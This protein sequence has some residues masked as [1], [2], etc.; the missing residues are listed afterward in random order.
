MRSTPWQ[1]RVIAAGAQAELHRVA[2]APA[3]PPAATASRPSCAAR[4]RARSRA[5]C[6]CASRPAPRACPGAGS[7][8]R[9]PRRSWR[10][11]ARVGCFVASSFDASDSRARR[12]PRARPPACARSSSS[13]WPGWSTAGGCTGRPSARVIAHR[14]R[15]FAAVVRHR[16][17]AR[18]A[19]APQAGQVVGLGVLDRAVEAALAAAAGVDV[20]QAQAARAAPRPGAA[21]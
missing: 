9:R 14:A 6:G 13:R 18:G 8:R 2:L 21:R 1:K 10:A 17:A 3:R 15:R 16:L 4:T 5:A 7:A 19:R 12:R 20:P 11:P